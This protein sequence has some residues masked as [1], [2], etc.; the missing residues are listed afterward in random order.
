MSFVKGMAV[1]VLTGAIAGVVLM[2]KPRHQC[3]HMR[4]SADKAAR[5]IGELVDSIISV[6]V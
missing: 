2:P 3:R 6:L 1:G 4:K 5:S